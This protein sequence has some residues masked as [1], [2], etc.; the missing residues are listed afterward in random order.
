MQNTI[1]QRLFLL[2][3]DSAKNIRLDKF[4]SQNKVIYSYLNLFS[5][6]YEE[7]TILKA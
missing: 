7:W 4:I 5:E 3:M 1:H 2:E 6:Y